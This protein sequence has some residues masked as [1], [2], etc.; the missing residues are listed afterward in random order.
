VH[1]AFI[2]DVDTLNWFLDF[3][4]ADIAG[5]GSHGFVGS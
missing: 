3:S 1:D 4:L 2:A 5:V